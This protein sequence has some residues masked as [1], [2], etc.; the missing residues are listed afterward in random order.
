MLSINY[1][2]EICM[3]MGLISYLCLLFQE[4]FE[5]INM[6]YQADVN[7]RLICVNELDSFMCIYG[8]NMKCIIHNILMKVEGN[9]I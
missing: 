4:I 9:I 5:K 3:E 6:S 7:K 1:S 2:R 8:N